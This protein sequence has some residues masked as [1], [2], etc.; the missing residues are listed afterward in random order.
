MMWI[1]YKLRKYKWW[2]KWRGLPDPVLEPYSSIERE[3][4]RIAHEQFAKADGRRK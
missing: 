3:A 1:D 2:R 4:L